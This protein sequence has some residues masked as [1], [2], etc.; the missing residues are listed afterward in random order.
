MVTTVG[1]TRCVVF[2]VSGRVL[3]LPTVDVRRVL[4]LPLLDRPPTAP[5]VVAGLFRHR[6]RAVPV[7]RLDR[8]L[9]LQQAA[10]DLYAPLL[11]L[12]RGG[13]PLAL[14]TDRVLDVVAI[15]AESVSA[16]DHALTFNGCAV[17]SVP[18]RT[19]RAT[20]L[21]AERLLTEVEGR[22]LADFQAIAD[23]RLAHWTPPP[24]GSQAEASS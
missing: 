17:A 8:L 3:A 12:E 1:A 21:A 19:T 18:Y 23:E 16:A 15:P 4:P 2:S 6:G 10:P 11:L 22:L 14:L 7:L 24:P 9:G 13:R 5:P 20:L